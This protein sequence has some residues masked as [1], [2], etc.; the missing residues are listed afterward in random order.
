[1]VV[2]LLEKDFD[3]VVNIW[4]VISFNELCCDGFECE[5]WNWLYFEVELCVSY[6]VRC[7]VGC[8]GLVVVVID[9]MKS[10]VVLGVIEF[11]GDI[12]YEF[13]SV[14]V[15]YG[16]VVCGW[17]DSFFGFFIVVEYVIFLVVVFYV[18]D[19]GFCFVW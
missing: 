7:F 1:M 5:R 3:V 9:Y 15:E 13:R 2:E 4:S 19:Y 12:I 14:I 8:G 17:V 16:W 11:F 18:V 6:V 10:Y